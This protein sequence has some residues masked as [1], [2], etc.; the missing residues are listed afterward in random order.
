MTIVEKIEALHKRLERAKEIVERGYIYPIYGRPGVYV[1]KSATGQKDGKGHLKLYLV[2]EE[3]CT[4]ADFRRLAKVN[5]G[6]CKHRLAREILMSQSE[7]EEGSDEA[8]SA[9]AQGDREA[10]GKAGRRR[11]QPTRTVDK[12]RA[13]RAGQN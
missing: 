7:K 13:A 6:W 3:G 10:S 8:Q 12:R 1:A 5:G 11:T 9:Q 2:D 4:C